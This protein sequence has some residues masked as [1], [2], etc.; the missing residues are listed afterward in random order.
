MVW[1][2][3][4]S[5]SVVLNFLTMQSELESHKKARTP[6]RWCK[7]MVNGG[8]G[9]VDDNDDADIERQREP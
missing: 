5:E 6:P 8:N 4:V 9:S 1:V 7:M 3:L 2:F